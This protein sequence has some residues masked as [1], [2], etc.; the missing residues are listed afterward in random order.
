MDSTRPRREVRGRGRRCRDAVDERQTAGPPG[1][2]TRPVLDEVPLVTVVE[3]LRRDHD[4]R[5]HVIDPPR[6]PIAQ[7]LR[8]DRPE[9]RRVV[10]V[11]LE[12]PAEERQHGDL[13][14]QLRSSLA[15][16]RG[17]A[18]TGEVDRDRRRQ[19]RTGGGPGEEVEVVPGRRT[20]RPFERREQRRRDQ[21]P[22]PAPV[23]R[24]DAPGHPRC[25]RMPGSLHDS[26]VGLA[27]TTNPA[28][29]APPFR[30]PDFTWSGRRRP[31]L[32][33][34]ARQDA[35]Q[36]RRRMVPL[37]LWILGVPGLIIILL[38]LLGIIKL[39]RPRGAGCRA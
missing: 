13:P 22:D 4:V 23:D 3:A 36:R 38:L 39:T 21:A 10:H 7:L 27:V 16:Q 24:E 28:M 30:E 19:D 8:D 11:A 31:R 34:A 1:L 14:E 15:I 6:G 17:E 2:A 12:D 32:R 9:I 35:R 37:L 25:S 29:R 26:R 20:R 5:G 33:V 18:L